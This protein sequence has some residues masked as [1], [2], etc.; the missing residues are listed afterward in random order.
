MR[1]ESDNPVDLI[2]IREWYKIISFL[3]SD[4]TVFGVG[5]VL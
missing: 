2:G 4:T 3:E 1:H 5:T